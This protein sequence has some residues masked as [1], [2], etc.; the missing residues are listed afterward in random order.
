MTTQTEL[1]KQP[2]EAA[3]KHTLSATYYNTSGKWKAALMLSNQGPNEMPVQITLY[4][5][6][7]EQFDLL[8]LTFKAHEVKTIDLDEHVPSSEFHKGSLQVTYQGRQLELGGVLMLTKPHQRLSFDEELVETKYSASNR[9][10]GLWWT[11]QNDAK[12]KLAVSNNSDN[13]VIATVKIDGVLHE[14]L[15]PQKIS[16]HAHQT[17]ILS[18]QEIVGEDAESLAEIGSIS[19]S[20][21]GANGAVLA[22][23]FMQDNAVGYS[24]VI[25]FI[26]PAKLKSSKIDAVGLRIGKLD[27]RKLVQGVVVRNIGATAVKLS[28]FLSYIKANGSGEIDFPALT[29]APGETRKLDTDS[30][31]INRQDVVASGLHFEHTG[32]PGQVIISTQSM[33]RDGKH[34]FRVPMRDAALASST[35]LYPFT[36]ADN[37]NAIVYLQN[38]SE[39]SREYK[40][41]I[42]LDNGDSYVWGMKPLRAGKVTTFDLRRLR[43]EQVTDVNGKTIPLEVKAGKFLWSVCGSGKDQTIIGRIEQVDLSRGSSSTAAC[44]ACCPDSF[45]NASMYPDF[46]GYIGDTTQL[47]VYIDDEDCYGSPRLPYPAYGGVYF[48]SLDSSVATVGVYS[49]LATAQGAGS[50]QLTGYVNGYSYIN[51]AAENP[52]DEYCCDQV[53]VPFTCYSQCDVLPPTITSISPSRG[54]IGVTTRVEIN[55]DG[56]TSGTTINNITDVFASIVSITRTKIVADFAPI[57]NAT[58]GN[59]SVSV[60]VNGSNSNSVQFFVQIPTSLSYI[61]QGVYQGTGIT[62]NGC[63]TSAPYGFNASLRAQVLDQQGQ[64][65]VATL[66]LRE[67]LKDFT[68][69]GNPNVFPDA[70]NTL[71]TASGTTEADG[72]FTDEP[73]GVQANFEFFSATYT[74]EVF[75]P[76]SSTVKPVIRTNDFITSGAA[77]CGSITNNVDIAVVVECP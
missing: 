24:N 4:N 39:S 69:D 38:V 70:P 33:S 31:D 47:T 10:E 2:Q 61:S 11:N 7:G 41:Q 26:D 60:N 64:S 3:E 6:C 49:G 74:Q 65:I 25:E 1:T 35:G 15:E 9:L 21:D 14:Q 73:V 27:G 28:G 53:S 54:C 46:T 58:G 32:E 37:Q 29:L 8:P 55:G 30:L 19:L 5:V 77:G 66:P 34:N 62:A 59:K 17:Q 56:F 16:L 75:I 57:V 42:D 44:G 76:F 40:V 18:L 45:V 67:N 51:C 13:C 72:K 71:V 22:R 36:L 63:P 48:D 52:D 50:T 43:D 23:G 68:V 12:L 20:H